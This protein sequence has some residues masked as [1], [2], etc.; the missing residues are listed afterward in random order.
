MPNFNG[1]GPR[2][3]GPMTGRGMGPCAGGPSFGRGCFKRGR[4]FGMGR[5]FTAD[6]EKTYFKEYLQDLQTEVKEIEEYLKSMEA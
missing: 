3:A 6:E 4:G 2:G 5:Q 1:Q